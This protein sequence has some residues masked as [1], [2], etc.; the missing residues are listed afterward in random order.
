[1]TQDRGNACL[2]LGWWREVATEGARG[3]TEAAPDG[4]EAVSSQG[5][6]DGMEADSHAGASAPASRPRGS[7]RRNGSRW[8]EILLPIWNCIQSSNGL[9]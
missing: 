7:R 1:M 6:Y 3:G 4:P 2:E 5:C 9:Y 8:W